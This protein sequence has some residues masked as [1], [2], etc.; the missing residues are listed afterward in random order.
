M[1][2]TTNFFGDD[3]PT[4]GACIM[5]CGAAVLVLELTGFASGNYSP[6]FSQDPDSNSEQQNAATPL[7]SSGGS[8]I[9]KNYFVPEPHSDSWDDAVCKSLIVCS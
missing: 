7:P 6:L 5:V 4:L 9:S 8:I 3:Q 1:T 2:H